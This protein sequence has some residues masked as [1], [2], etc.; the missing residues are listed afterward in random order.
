M[1]KV[2]NVLSAYV[3]MI[4]SLLLMFSMIPALAADQ[5]N[6]KTQMSA[7]D[8]VDLLVDKGVISTDDA[9]ALKKKAAE[10]ENVKAK[11]AKT[12]PS[13]TFKTRLEARFSSVQQDNGQPNWGSRDDVKGGDGF[14]IRRARFH[15]LGELNQDIGYTV[16]FSSDFGASNP[17]L[18]VGSMEW[19]GWKDANLSAGIL[20][21]PFGWEIQTNDSI[22]LQ[23]DLAAVS[24]LIPP[25]K[26]NGIRLDSKKPLFGNVQYQFMLGNGSGRN[27]ANP[28]DSYMIATRLYAP[29][30][31]NF[32]LGLSNC[33]NPNTDTSS[34]QSRFLKNNL[35]G[36]ADPYGLLPAY[37]AKQ[38]DESMWGVDFQ[39]NSNHD[40]MRGE[41]MRMNI[42]RG[43]MGSEINSEGYYLVYSRGLEYAGIPDK[44][45]LVTGIQEYDPN[46]GIRDKYDLTSYLLGLNFHIG[47]SKRYGCR[48]GAMPCQSM[49]RLNYIWNEEARDSVSNN[50]WVC[51]YQTW[52]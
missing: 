49:I 23:A 50:K 17:T 35:T 6:T 46:T 38:V 30:N 52:F 20:N 27:A 12:Y 42:D 22:Y 9:T 37:A 19:K 43:N 44:L 10:T 13:V 11:E 26:D 40:T 48:G 3:L 25:D 18:L 45:E 28:N 2:N 32:T 15:M 36:T 33:I 14:V 47:D 1:L 5:P 41:Y 7:D 51:Q 39:W 8:L 4:I 31:K 34:Y 24:M 21:V 29:V 16:V